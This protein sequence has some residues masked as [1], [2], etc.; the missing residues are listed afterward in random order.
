MMEAKV[1]VSQDRLFRKNVLLHHPEEDLEEGV[2]Y[3]DLLER[4]GTTNIISQNALIPIF[5]SFHNRFKVITSK[6]NL[7]NVP[8]PGLRFTALNDKWM[9]SE[10]VSPNKIR[11]A[12]EILDSI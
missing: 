12:Q 5:K 9:V 3:D 8:I 10:L 4:M 7:P 6:A 11:S 1:F 2:S